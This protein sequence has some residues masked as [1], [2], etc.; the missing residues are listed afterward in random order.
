MTVSNS[1]FSINLLRIVRQGLLR[2]F[3]SNAHTPMRPI[4]LD[5]RSRSRSWASNDAATV[6]LADA[7]FAG[8]LVATGKLDAEFGVV[9]AA[10]AGGLDAVFGARAGATGWG[11][12]G[13]AIADLERCE[14]SGGGWAGAAWTWMPMPSWVDVRAVEGFETTFTGEVATVG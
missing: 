7:R 10:A 3:A 9:A 5:L 1:P 11:P 12:S 14:C 8:K 4:T 13:R 6:E 2:A